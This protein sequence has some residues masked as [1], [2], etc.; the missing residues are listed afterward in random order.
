[1]LATAVFAVMRWLRTHATRV[2]VCF[3]SSRCFYRVIVRVALRCGCLTWPCGRSVCVCWVSIDSVMFIGVCV[4][5]GLG[6]V[7]FVCQLKWGNVL[8]MF[9]FFGGGGEED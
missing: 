1:M 6:C 7:V 8:F 9:F 4:N 3:I 2:Y 5:V